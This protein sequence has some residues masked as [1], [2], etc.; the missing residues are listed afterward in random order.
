[1]AL[2]SVSQKVMLREAN[3]CLNTNFGS[4]VQHILSQQGC[5]EHPGQ[6]FA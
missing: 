2:E 4:L 5:M 3:Q 1:M 6:S